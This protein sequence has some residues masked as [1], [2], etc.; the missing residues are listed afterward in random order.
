MEIYQTKADDATINSAIDTMIKILEEN[1]DKFVDNLPIKVN[2]F[3]FTQKEEKDQKEWKKNN[4][5]DENA[6]AEQAFNFLKD[7]Y[8]IEMMI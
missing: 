1:K 2:P 4:N 7:K 6:T 3:K 8:K 5:I